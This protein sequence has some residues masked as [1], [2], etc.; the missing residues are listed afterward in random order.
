[1]SATRTRPRAGSQRRR[2]RSDHQPEPAR[3]APFNGAAATDLAELEWLVP[4]V[5]VELVEAPPVAPG[6]PGVAEPGSWW[7]WCSERE[8]ARAER[9][10]PLWEMSPARRIDAMR[11]GELTYDQL[12]TWSARHPEQVPMLNGEFEWIAARTPEVCE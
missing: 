12:A 10:R 8:L 6:P 3:D 5:A 9:L 4:D 1:M 7:E 11:R 2:P